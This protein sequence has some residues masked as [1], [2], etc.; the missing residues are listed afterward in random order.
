[1][2][3]IRVDTEHVQNIFRSQY[4]TKVVNFRLLVD[5]ISFLLERMK[6]LAFM[7]YLSAALNQS[8]HLSH[9]GEKCDMW[10]DSACDLKTFSIS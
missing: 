2:Y 10:F 1:M 8:L 3:E 4:Q 5:A 6:L 7:Y 9:P